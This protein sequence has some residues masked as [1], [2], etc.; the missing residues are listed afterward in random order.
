MIKG[1]FEFGPENMDLSIY[2]YKSGL[3]STLG[4]DLLIKPADFKLCMEIKGENPAENRM[5]LELN[6]DSME[7]VSLM[8]GGKINDAVLTVGHKNEIESEIK[9]NKILDV[10]RY[11]KII[12][13]SRKIFKETNCLKVTGDLAIRDTIKE[14]ELIL[15]K[16]IEPPGSKIYG[17]FDLYQS[18]FGIR[19]YSAMFG[20]L[21]L[22][23]KIEIKFNINI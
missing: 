15:K 18:K 22:K 13:T 14:I 9:S 20:T 19:P 16:D 8:A 5:E 4:Y 2:A 1:L 23:D 17:S 12:F 11:P 7:V 3:L 6:T 21:H 10:K